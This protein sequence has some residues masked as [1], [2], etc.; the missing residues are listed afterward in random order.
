MR[1]ISH[2]REYPIYISIEGGYYST[3]NELIGSER[4]S[5]R[6]CRKTFEKIW[7][8]CLLEMK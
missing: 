6:Q 2:Y 1:Y 7:Q 3:G 5:K 8:D 4:K